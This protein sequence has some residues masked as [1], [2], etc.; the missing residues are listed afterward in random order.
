MRR[1]G[2]FR[3]SLEIG[4]PAQSSW[5]ALEAVVDPEATFTWIPQSV[6][7]R[8]GVRPSERI[9]FE[10]AGGTVIAREV[11]ETPVRIGGVV[12]VAPVVFGDERTPPQCC[13]GCHL[14]PEV[15]C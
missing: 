7:E 13:L 4:N 9:E 1:V 12:H 10:T 3:V 6:L 2:T 11:G 14:S 8:L 15:S 5:E